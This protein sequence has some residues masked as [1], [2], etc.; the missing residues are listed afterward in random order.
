MDSLNLDRALRLKTNAM[1]GG[2]LAIYMR[3]DCRSGLDAVVQI[4][5]NYEKARR[6]P[7]CPWCAT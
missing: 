7:S 3:D 5:F 1:R 2:T 4:D 6:G